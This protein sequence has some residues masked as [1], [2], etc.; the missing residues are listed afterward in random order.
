LWSCRSYWEG[1]ESGGCGCEFRCT[2]WRETFRFKGFHVGLG[3]FETLHVG[4]KHAVGF[5]GERFRVMDE[6]KRD[7]RFQRSDAH[8]I[9]GGSIRICLHWVRQVSVDV[10]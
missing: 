8:S 4:C 3:I 10:K 9:W 1:A 7:M 2:E 5:T 6:M